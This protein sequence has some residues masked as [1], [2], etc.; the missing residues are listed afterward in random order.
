MQVNITMVIIVAVVCM[1]FGYFFGLFE[2]RARGYKKRKAEEETGKVEAEPQVQVIEAPAP[3]VFDD[4][5]LLRLREDGGK[6]Q[7]ELDGTP[8]P[9]DAVAP[10]QRKRLI[11]LITRIRPWVEGRQAAAS[12][13][14]Q[15]V[16]PI[17]QPVAPVVLV[18]P[19][20]KEEPTTPKTMVGQIDYIL[21]ERIADTPLAKRGIKLEESPGGGVAVVVGIKRYPGLGDVPDEEVQTVIRAA[22]AEWERKFTPGM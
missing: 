1:F 6:F 19:I 22:I 5:G 11:E 13:V 10:E 16:T 7:V 12:A 20:K 21:Q 9:F 15:L 14:S 2:G 4:P 3:V 8:I 18:P 17:S